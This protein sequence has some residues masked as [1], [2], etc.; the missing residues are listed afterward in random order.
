MGGRYKGRG[1]WVRG[2]V[3]GC[4]GGWVGGRVDGWAVSR[5][6]G[7]EG[8]KGRPHGSCC[9][10]RCMQILNASALLGAAPHLSS[11][12]VLALCLRFHHKLCSLLRCRL[13]CPACSSA[14]SGQHRRRPLWHLHPRRRLPAL[15]REP[16]PHPGRGPL[17]PHRGLQCKPARPGGARRGPECGGRHNHED[18]AADRCGGCGVAGVS[19]CV[20]G[21]VWW[22]G[23]RG[24]NAP[25][26]AVRPLH[27]C[28]ACE[29]VWTVHCLVGS[30]TPAHLPT[31]PPPFL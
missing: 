28:S 12:S 23:R 16:A 7:A 24:E 14:R 8:G 31:C 3:D 9:W 11:S 29:C 10:C 26:A 6:G 13:P 30:S 21:C 22:L 1:G 25:A 15:G 17:H 4:V 2:Q 20:G 19:G 27:S 18:G 5:A